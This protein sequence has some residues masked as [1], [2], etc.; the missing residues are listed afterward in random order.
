MYTTIDLIFHSSNNYK[1]SG[2]HSLAVSLVGN[3][4]N[5]PE[6]QYPESRHYLV[7]HV[8]VLYYD[9]GTWEKKFE[10]HGSKGL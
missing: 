9:S 8:H 5:I 2:F 4:W 1:I 6:H 3:Q 7:Q 10:K